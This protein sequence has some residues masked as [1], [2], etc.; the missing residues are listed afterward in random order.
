ML[1]QRCAEAPAAVV[2]ELKVS[3]TGQTVALCH[4]CYR[5]CRTVAATVRAGR[6]LQQGGEPTPWGV[7]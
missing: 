4:D 7:R 3:E 5:Y 1:C 2:A 6:P